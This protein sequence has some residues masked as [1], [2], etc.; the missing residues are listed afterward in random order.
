MTNHTEEQEDIMNRNEM[1][2][3]V[4]AGLRR[5]GKKPDALLFLQQYANNYTWDEGT[6]CGLPVYHGELLINQ[7][8]DSMVCNAIFTPIFLKD[9]ASSFE[10]V[11][12]FCQG[13]DEC[14][15]ILPGK[16]RRRT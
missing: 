12:A 13:F 6:I 4:Q 15:G 5:M 14:L 9:D 16:T 2:D 3:R 10:N 8:A 7:R 11:W 1:I